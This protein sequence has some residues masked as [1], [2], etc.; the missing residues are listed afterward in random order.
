MGIFNDRKTNLQQ[1]SIVPT[2][3]MRQAGRYHSHYQNLKRKHD[4]MTLCKT[5][6][7]A[8][9][10]TLGPIK[11]FDFDAAILFSDILFP[12]EQL[13]FSLSYADG[14]PTLGLKLTSSQSFNLVKKVEPAS[15]FYQFQKEALK[16]IRRELPPNKTLLGFIGAPFTL[17]TYAIEGA[18]R[19]NLI[20]SKKG[21]YD[22]RY[23]RFQE[24]LLPELLENIKI[25]VEGGADAICL[26]DTSAGELSLHDY[27]KFV[28]PV[29]R[30]LTFNLKSSHPT[31]KI[32]YYSRTTHLHYLYAIEDPNIDVLGVDWRIDL[33]EALRILG[34]D[35]YIQGNI[36]PVWTQLPWKILK[37]NLNTFWNKLT[38]ENIPLERWIC[39]LGHG[40]L[41][42]TPE[43]N[44]Q[45]MVEY[46]HQTFVY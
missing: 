41:P 30:E 14:P 11:D 25:Q 43:E 35:Y 37:T 17:Y 1:Q 15:S 40:V 27:K 33:S 6:E 32:I 23:S 4:F 31:I 5:P 16:L 13:N 45:K 19:G 3:F 8:C 22:G 42:Q 20:E 29:V 2:W 28:I 39:S 12:L 26:F 10:V 9:E 34:D 38:E 24:I 21:L 7:L 44:I 36:D 46:I 18:H